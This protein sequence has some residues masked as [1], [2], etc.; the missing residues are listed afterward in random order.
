MFTAKASGINKRNF[1]YQWKRRGKNNIPTKA[2]GVKR[3]VLRIPKLKDEDEGQYY[4]TVTNEW[5]NKEV[6]KDVTLTVKGN[7]PML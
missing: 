4:C 6:S 1:K 5:N 2:S 7:K 3:A